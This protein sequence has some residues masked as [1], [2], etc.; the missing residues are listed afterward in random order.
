MGFKIGDSVKYKNED[1]VVESIKSLG[2]KT[3]Y[4]LKKGNYKV[5][6]FGNQSSGITAN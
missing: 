4:V 6:I 2:V 5:A 3:S 1:Y